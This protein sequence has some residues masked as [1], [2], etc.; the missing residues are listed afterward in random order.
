[1]RLWLLATACMLCGVM[2]A[3]RLRQGKCLQAD[4]CLESASKGYRLCFRTDGS[5]MAVYNSANTSVWD[6]STSGIIFVA[7]NTCSPPDKLCLQDDGN[8]VLVSSGSSCWGAFND[9]E[10][11]MRQRGPAPAQALLLDDG[12]LQLFDAF[13]TSYW[14]STNGKPDTPSASPSGRDACAGEFV[15]AVT[16]CTWSS[17]TVSIHDPSVP[18]AWPMLQH[19][20]APA[21]CMS[22]CSHCGTV[23]VAHDYAC[24][25]VC[26]ADRST[27]STA[28]S[29]GLAFPPSHVL[30]DRPAP[31]SS[32]APGDS[33]SP[34]AQPPEAAT[35]LSTLLARA[36]RPEDPGV[37]T[38]CSAAAGLK[39]QASDSVDV[40]ACPAAAS[41]EELLKSCDVTLPVVCLNE[42]TRSDDSYVV[43]NSVASLG[44]IGTTGELN[45][46]KYVCSCILQMHVLMSWN[47]T[48][49]HFCWVMLWCLEH[50]ICCASRPCSV[51]FMGG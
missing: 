51:R 41:G 39:P 44:G 3:D 4:G 37:N 25:R 33:A 48:S 11:L 5:P 32:S 31:A 12:S 40:Q 47:S 8:L 34:T 6:I 24:V 49:Q 23:C 36:T 7:G 16:S 38:D 19:A 35:G 2:A 13:C 43:P 20:I 27:A 30:I 14:D 26:V 21:W 10:V 17:L 29:D 45:Q 50:S 18:V 42:K 46:A 28:S 15:S 1:M 9:P 22:S